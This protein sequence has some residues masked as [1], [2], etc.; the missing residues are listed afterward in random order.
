MD[1][2]NETENL[3][4]L[5]ISGQNSE[6][7]QRVGARLV[8][9]IEKISDRIVEASGVEKDP[10]STT[11]EDITSIATRWAQA[12]VEKPSLE[13]DVLKANIMKAL[14]EARKIDHESAKIA[15]ENRNSEILGMIDA[16]DRLVD[17][18]IKMQKSGISIKLENGKI[19]SLANDESE[20]LPNNAINSDSKK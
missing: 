8:T 18:Q 19:D 5:H 10:S 2:A 7:W 9:L 16:M 14:A 6:E 1:S 17:L 12:K 3:V 15:T 11:V 13:N 20:I 4:T